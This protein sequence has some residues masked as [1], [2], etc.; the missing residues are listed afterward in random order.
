MQPRR[1][2]IHLLSSNRW[3][4]AQRYALDICTHFKSKGW[5]V[6]AMTRDAKVVDMHFKQAEIPLLHAPLRGFFDPASAVIMAKVL[7]G[8]PRDLTV[9]H[10]H[11][12]R[13]AFTVL[14]AK[15]LIGRPDIRIVSTRHTIRHGRNSW[16]FRRIYD[17]INAH[18][19]V[20]KAA[21]ERFSSSWPFRL[22]MRPETVH[23]LLN[24]INIPARKPVAEPTRGP[25]FAIY[26]GPVSP[27]KGMETLI[28]ALGNLRD[29]KLRLRIVGTGN[30]DYID[31]LRRRA[32]HRGVM[33]MID[34][35]NQPDV[36]AELLD[37]SHFAV[38]PSIEREAFGLA[39]LHVMAAGRAQVCTANGAQG[40]YLCDGVTALFAKPADAVSLAQ[41]MR[42]LV[43]DPEL[44]KNIGERAYQAY[45]S[46]L[47]W[48]TF[49]NK[50]TEIYTTC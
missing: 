25:I 3:G 45:T 2:L 11:R 43:E 7:K 28:D 24:S 29:L 50:L 46:S 13:D 22:P 37:Q 39:N 47:S 23:T 35:K 19:F 30:P 36:S 5:Q 1:V 40:E 12:Y 14:L 17:K 26:T 16:L 21:L 15:R 9:V 33:E 31:S 8:T 42:K 48:D 34:W 4:G 41:A 6:A 18:I 32:M 10:V 27:G 20:S 49:I 44:R 38:L